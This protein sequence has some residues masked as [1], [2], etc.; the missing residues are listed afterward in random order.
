MKEHDIESMRD[1]LDGRISPGNLA[2]LNRLLESDAGARARFRSLATLEEGL[3][4]LAAV[5]DPSRLNPVEPATPAS[6]IANVTRFN[7]PPRNSWVRLF[8]QP[9]AAAVAGLLIGVFCTSAI[10]AG[11]ES[12]RQNILNLLQ[13]SFEFGPPPRVTGIPLKPGLWSGDYTEVV[14]R[15]QSIEPADGNR[16]LRFLR[17]D[18]EGKASP[19]GSYIGEFYQLVDLRLYQKE[20]AD[21]GAVVQAS[22]S[23]NA[24][25]FPPE[26]VYGCAASIYALD[27]R[28]ATNGAARTDQ[29]L[30]ADCLAMARDSRMKLD[31][32]PAAWQQLNAELRLPP[33]TEFLMIRFG[34]GHATRPQRRETF[35]GHYL[36][37][38][39]L[40]LLR[41]A[42]L[43]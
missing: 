6:W 34:V 5:A 8:S 29:A 3:R 4:D 40:T 9:L 32:N 36:D 38:V 20:F 43:H 26:E 31:R 18:F 11:S 19:E 13:D 1:Y 41:R 12:G 28:T 22:A 7:L 35:D 2:E 33:D 17:A 27:A 25:Q 37:N 42:A 21:G 24:L 16:M 39:R 10:W 30:T 14:T 15:Q 23:F